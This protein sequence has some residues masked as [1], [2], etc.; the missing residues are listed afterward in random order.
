MSIIP[1][2]TTTAPAGRTYYRMTSP[3]S[4]PR[5]PSHYR[6]VVN[7]EGAIM[8]RLGARYNHPGAR[9]VYLAEDPLTCL[10]EKMYYFHRDFLSDPFT[11]H[12]TDLLDFAAGEIRVI[13]GPNPPSLN[14]SLDAY[15]AWTRV[16]FNH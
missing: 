13:P 15:R 1:G 11:N 5:R 4:S 7:G 2:L 8:N 14:P 12:A 16:E 6:R 10:A 3:D 9:A